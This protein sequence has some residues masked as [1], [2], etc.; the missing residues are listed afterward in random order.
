MSRSV[1]QGDGQ[2]EM[3]SL[4]PLRRD[5]TQRSNKIDTSTY[6]SWTSFDRICARS[7]SVQSHRKHPAT[8]SQQILQRPAL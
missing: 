4:H 2:G 5:Y 8:S 7:R 1:Q 3:R 6:G